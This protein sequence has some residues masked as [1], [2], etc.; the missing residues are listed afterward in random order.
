M[1]PD[2]ELLGVCW[3]L[4]RAA[5]ICYCICTWAEKVYGAC[6]LYMPRK[7]LAVSGAAGR[8]MCCAMPCRAMSMTGVTPWPPLPFT[9]L[10]LLQQLLPCH[11]TAAVRPPAAP[12]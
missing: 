1:L 10:P 4:H 9:V 3:L 12:H 5:M 2:W 11:P 7:C 6:R 8:H